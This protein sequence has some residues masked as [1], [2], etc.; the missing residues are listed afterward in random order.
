MFILNRQQKRFRRSKNVVEFTE[1]LKK[2]GFDIPNLWEKN[3]AEVIETAEEP[4]KTI[5][6]IQKRAALILKDKD[7]F[8]VTFARLAW[9]NIWSK[10]F[11]ALDG[12]ICA[13][14]KDSIYLLRILTRTTLE[15]QLHLH[16]IMKPMLNLYEQNQKPVS[17]QSKKE[18]ETIL[19]NRL[20]A[21]ASW[22]I[23]NDRLHYKKFLKPD[24]L[25]A[26]W[27][28]EPALKI[29]NDPDSIMVHEAI[30]G[31]LD[32]ETNHRKLKKGRL[33]QQN[34]GY[35]RIR[36]L[37]TWLNHPVLARWH[38]KLK[39]L[40]G[41][42]KKNFV[43]FFSLIEDEQMG[44]PKEMKNIEIP[45]AY[46]VYNEGSMAIHGSSLDQFLHFGE[47]K[48]TPLFMGLP[49][50]IISVAQQIGRT[51]NHIIVWLFLLQTVI[52]SI[53]NESQP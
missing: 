28:P 29:L 47:T 27:D 11:S 18:K 39:F 35:H 25:E 21:Y 48:V 31:K 37:E 33:I 30:F 10:T 50:E 46:P 4:S 51:C 19:T 16:T 23:W 8:Q 53:K 40:A 52:W 42:K 38:Q 36:K 49:E 24:V 45:F 15:L 13:L 12:T 34:T 44:I 3:W 43:T 1:D 5:I 2:M 7:Q 14:A 22:C 20:E 32:V 6:R 26:V 17:D 41:T 9:L